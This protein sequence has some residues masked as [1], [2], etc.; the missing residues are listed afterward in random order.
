M[1][2]VTDFIHHIWRIDLFFAIRH[3][4][5]KKARNCLIVGIVLAVI[6]F[7]IPILMLATIPDY[8]FE[9]EWVYQIGKDNLGWV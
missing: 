8:S 3:D 5:P 1:V 7:I 4:D 6:P 9:E 2:S